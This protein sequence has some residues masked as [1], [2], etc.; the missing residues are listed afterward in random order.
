[1][2]EILTAVGNRI[3][4]IREERNWSQEEL[5]HA[6]DINRTFLGELERGEKKASIETIEKI[7]HAFEIS[8]SDFFNPIQPS[9]KY[10]GDTTLTLLIEKLNT[11][12]VDDHKTMVGIFD[13]L[14]GGRTDKEK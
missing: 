1:M 5:A 3:R 9:S 6:A 8:L 14:F 4:N 11:V 2:S 7:V 10:N 12:S 13:V